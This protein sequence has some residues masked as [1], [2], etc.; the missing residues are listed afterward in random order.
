MQDLCPVQEVWQGFVTRAGGGRAV[1]DPEKMDELPESS[2]REI[3]PSNSEGST[4]I[5]SLQI[6]AMGK[7]K[8]DEQEAQKGSETQFT[9]ARPIVA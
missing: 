4:Q 3:E 9:M 2:Q 5:S 6:L 8:E 1:I 7:E